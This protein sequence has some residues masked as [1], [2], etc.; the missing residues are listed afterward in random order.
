MNNQ[1]DNLTAENEMH[2]FAKITFDEAEE[3]G[4]EF[5]I[6]RGDEVVANYYSREE[7]EEALTAY[8]A[9]GYRIV[10]AWKYMNKKIKIRKSWGRP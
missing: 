3:I 6:M 5:Y 2:S 7:A 9:P 8:R 10:R 4:V 1:F